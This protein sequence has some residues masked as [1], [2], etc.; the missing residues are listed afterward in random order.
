MIYD[1]HEIY[2]NWKNA[3][4]R[5]AQ[6]RILAELNAVSNKQI[7]DIILKKQKEEEERDAQYKKVLEEQAQK[8]ADEAVVL[9]DDT[10]KAI[11]A[12]LDELDILIKGY[13]NEYRRLS[14]ILMRRKV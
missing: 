7:T 5:K 14:N 8:K 13:Q 6:V 11:T 1:E 12:R 2:L 3:K 4:N 10:Y 9:N